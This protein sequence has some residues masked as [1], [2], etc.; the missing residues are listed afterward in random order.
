MTNTSNSVSDSL[1]EKIDEFN[2]DVLLKLSELKKENG[3]YKSALTLFYKVL[4]LEENNINAILG[5][6]DIYLLEG[7]LEKSQ[8]FYLKSLIFISII[9]TYDFCLKYITLINYPLC[10]AAFFPINVIKSILTKQIST[11]YNTKE[12]ITISI[13][14]I[15]I[16][17]TARLNLG[18][19]NFTPL[20]VTCFL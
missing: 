1:S 6:A 3:E 2:R 7:D 10:Q 20:M 17:L 19:L 9:T 5:I 13:L 11:E 12:A 16:C 15:I 18:I 8:K 14:P 4:N